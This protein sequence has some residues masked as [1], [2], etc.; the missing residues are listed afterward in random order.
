MLISCG[1]SSAGGD[2]DE[3]SKLI[4]RNLSLA[5]SETHLTAGHDV[6]VPQY[7]GKILFIE[8]LE[9][10]ATVANAQ[11][12]EVALVADVSVAVARFTGRRAGLS[13]DEVPHPQADVKDNEVGETIERA[14]QRLERLNDLRPSIRQVDAAADLENTYAALQLALGNVSR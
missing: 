9:A 5:L 4:A 11:F 14:W 7:V 13:F 6:V 8:S 2:F 3:T 12:I 1:P 10:V